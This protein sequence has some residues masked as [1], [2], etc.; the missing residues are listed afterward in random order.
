MLEVN[1]ANMSEELGKTKGVQ[2][3]SIPVVRIGLVHL[4]LRSLAHFLWP[5]LA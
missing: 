1:K 5:S 4:S 2:L 3:K